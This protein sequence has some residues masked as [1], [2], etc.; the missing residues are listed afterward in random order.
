MSVNKFIGLGNVVRDPDIKRFDDENSVASFAIALNE[1]GY[2]AKNGTI[3]PERAE[4]VN[5]VCYKGLAT[6]A[7]R[8]VRKGD[9]LYIEGKIRTR[10]YDDKNQQKRYVTEIIAD[11]IELLGGRKEEQVQS[12]STAPTQRVSTAPTQPRGMYEHMEEQ[13]QGPSHYDDYL[14]F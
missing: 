5:I 7:E 11:K 14:P 4:F 9:P 10:S 1:K 2:T 6:I 13:K 3:V 8:F 12:V